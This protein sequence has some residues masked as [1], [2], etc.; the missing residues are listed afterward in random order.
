MVIEG[1]DHD[2]DHGNGSRTE[3]LDVR[4]L[5]FASEKNVV[6]AALGRRPGVIDVVANPTAQNATVTFDPSAA[7]VEDLQSWVQEC[8][9]HC[10]GLSVP[11][12][13]CE[14][15]PAPNAD[16]AH[17]AYDGHDGHGTTQVED[18]VDHDAHQGHPATMEP[19]HAGQGL[20]PEIAALTM[21]GSSIIVA[22]NAVLLKR[23]HLPAPVGATRA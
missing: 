6:E 18:H 1:H 19:G 23:L 22:A 15:L 13:I 11:N 9:Y 17:A 10:A 5:R 20:R 4:G 2:L 7:T 12:H 14:P 21:S 3:V 8:G 16:G